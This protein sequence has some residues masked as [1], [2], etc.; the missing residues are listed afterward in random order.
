M[1]FP[2]N[3]S[4]FWGT[5]DG[6]EVGGQTWEA[7]D[8]RPGKQEKWRIVVVPEGKFVVYDGRTEAA[9]GGRG[10]QQRVPS[11]ADS[12]TDPTSPETI[13]CYAVVHQDLKIR[14]HIQ[15]LF[16]FYTLA[17]YW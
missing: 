10:T 9:E 1:G 16:L 7:R 14:E 5:Q 8:D 2:T 13:F 15:Q 4:V 6:M 3:H 11:L 12:V 17:Q